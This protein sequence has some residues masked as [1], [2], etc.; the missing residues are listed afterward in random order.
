MDFG[1]RLL[2]FGSV[3]NRDGGSDHNV[4]SSAYLTPPAESS[5][6]L[7]FGP[8][9]PVP[10]AGVRLTVQQPNQYDL[11]SWLGSRAAPTSDAGDASTAGHGAPSVDAKAS[12]DAPAAQADGGTQSRPR[13]QSDTGRDLLSRDLWMKDS[14]ATHCYGCETMFTIL[15]RRHH[16]RRCGRVFCGR[17]TQKTI[18][19]SLLRSARPQTLKPEP[20]ADGVK[21]RVCDQCYAEALSSVP[22]AGGE[23]KPPSLPGNSSSAEGVRRPRVTGSGPLMYNPTDFVGTSFLRDSREAGPGGTEDDGSEMERA[24]SEG[25]GGDVPMSREWREREAVRAAYGL[26]RHSHTHAHAHG[27][28]N[29]RP[30]MYRRSVRVPCH[31]IEPWVDVQGGSFI[32]P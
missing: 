27:H 12:A 31:C 4:S 11:T 10:S 25:R 22:S 24:L 30:P 3:R 17:C 32:E 16:C 20:D 29:P 14:H 21:V 26:L 18:S 6:L 1:L 2:G 9:Q 8:Y 15:N 19:T 13:S 28:G 5:S 7:S 23:R